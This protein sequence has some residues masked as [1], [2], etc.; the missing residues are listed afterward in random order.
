MDSC[1]VKAFGHVPYGAGLGF[2]VCKRLS[3]VQ[4]FPGT[5]GNAK[6]TLILTPSP[7]LAHFHTDSDMKGDRALLC[8][9]EVPGRGEK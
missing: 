4:S 1:A 2:R 3:L 6:E 9:T 8:W 7:V 5:L